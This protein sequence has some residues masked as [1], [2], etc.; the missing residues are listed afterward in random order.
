MEALNRTLFLLIN[1]SA[2][3]NSA[4]IAL[5]MLFG[6]YAIWLVPATLVLGWLRGGRLGHA[7]SGILQRVRSSHLFHS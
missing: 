5:A 3:P 1:A 7:R 4:F 6:E 2:Q